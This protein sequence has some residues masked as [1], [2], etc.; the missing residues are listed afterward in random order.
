MKAMKDSH[1]RILFTHFSLTM[2]V[3]N[4][5]SF[6]ILDANEAIFRL[7]NFSREVFSL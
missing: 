1:V 6:Q 2:W 5:D 7:L 3:C 4:S